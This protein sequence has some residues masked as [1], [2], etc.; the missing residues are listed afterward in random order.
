MSRNEA[1]QFFF[2]S[3][4]KG[5]RCRTKE[6]ASYAPSVIWVAIVYE[7]GE[8][9]QE[10]VGNGVDSDVQFSRETLKRFCR[11]RLRPALHTDTAHC[12][13]KS[14]IYNSERT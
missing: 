9:W 11:R 3:Q 7:S 10:F 4:S 13:R 12:Q 8:D 2:L 1:P 14:A 5:T 6:P